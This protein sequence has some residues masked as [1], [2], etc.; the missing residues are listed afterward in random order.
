MVRETLIDTKAQRS[1]V[2]ILGD[3]TV[4]LDYD[5]VS[6]VI[7][8]EF[9]QKV[10]HDENYG[11]LS[12]Y[13]GFIANSRTFTAFQNEECVGIARLF[14]GV[15]ELPPFLTEMPFYDEDQRQK[16]M[17]FGRIGLL[18]EFG[19]IAV[20]KRM[21]KLFVFERLARL[22][23]RDSYSRDIEYW[24]VIMEPERVESMNKHYGFTFQ[25]L[26]DT[27]FYQGGDCAAHVMN[28]EEVYRNVQETQPEIFEWFCK[29]PLQK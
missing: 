21:R 24:G 10:W 3:V 23:Y 25:K 14:S 29:E 2:D 20:A 18:E 13:A 9:E 19:T 7:A 8:Q 17:D 16:L 1:E 5:P 15:A 22:A 26:G 12:D 27:V 4:R 28:L 11:S 6:L